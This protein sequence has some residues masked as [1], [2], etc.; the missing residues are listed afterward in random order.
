MPSSAS[1]NA[2]RPTPELALV[3]AR[4]AAAARST[5]PE[6]DTLAQI[7]LLVRAHRIAASRSSGR[8]ERETVPPPTRVPAPVPTAAPAR[9]PAH[10]RRRGHGRRSVLAIG[11]LAAAVLFSALLVGVRVTFEGQRAGAD[12]APT[13]RPPVAPTKPAAPQEKTSPKVRQTKPPR[14]KAK[15]QP[16]GPTPR[17]KPKAQR[18]VVAPRATPAAPVTGQ[19][20]R[21]V[22]APVSGA[23]AY[24]VQFFR[25]PRLVFDATTK[26]PEVTVPQE[27][28]FA[29]SRRS[30]VPG[31]YRWNV[32]PITAA[33][34]DSRA[35]VQ[36]RLVVGR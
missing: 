16:P 33:G 22:W 8:V 20:R 2:E 29:G 1:L 27:W 5:L 25:G 3:D 32:W 21:F 23:T 17:A 19:P 6:V 11:G 26:K 14:T 28:T 4:L 15:A 24:R 35:A 9:A 31:A 7:E 13:E 36:A 30:L 12:A 10:A 18:R 34:Q